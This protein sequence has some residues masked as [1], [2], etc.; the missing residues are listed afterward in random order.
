MFDEQVQIGRVGMRIGVDQCLVNGVQRRHSAV[1]RARIIHPTL[2]SFA[3]TLLAVVH[4]DLRACLASPVR[5]TA[6]RR[7]PDL[8]AARSPPPPELD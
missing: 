5:S 2:P 7:H 1:V 4:K 8:M 3:V 6:I